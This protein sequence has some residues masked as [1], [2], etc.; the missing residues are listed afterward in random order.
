M[1]FT[2]ARRRVLSVLVLG[3]AV[4]LAVGLYLFQPWRVFTNVRVDEAAIVAPDEGTVRTIA[5][6]SFIS[7]EHSTSGAVTLQ[8]LPDGEV[9]L[10]LTDLR[11][12]DGPALRVWLSDQPVQ[13]GLGRNLDDGEYV[14]LGALKG[15]EGNQNYVVPA[16]ADLTILRTV[17]VWCERFSVSFG[18]AALDPA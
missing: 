17:T 1:A 13:P 6:G 9:V 3:L 12:S 8:E 14:D 10:R 16:E 5:A 18:A 15:N 2:P 7:Q 11:T 4:I